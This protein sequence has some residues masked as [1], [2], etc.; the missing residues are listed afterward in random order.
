MQVCATTWP[1][2]QRVG[3]DQRVLCWLHGPASEIPT[4]GTAPLEREEI[5]VAEEA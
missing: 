5:A 3:M 2:E 4:G 1:I